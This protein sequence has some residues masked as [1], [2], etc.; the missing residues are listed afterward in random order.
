[1]AANTTREACSYG[2][3]KQTKRASQARG[4]VGQREGL[5]RPGH[6]SRGPRHPRALHEADESARTSP[7][8][9]APKNHNSCSD[10]LDA[11]A[12][13]VWQEMDSLDCRGGREAHL[14]AQADKRRTGA[15]HNV[16]HA[17]A[18]YGGRGRGV[19][20]R[21]HVGRA[22]NTRCGI[23]ARDA[24]QHGKRTKIQPLVVATMMQSSLWMLGARR[25]GCILAATR[26]RRHARK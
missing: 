26:T 13:H 11:A 25:S 2:G 15:S 22:R 5:A 20:N 4:K 10:G 18:T 3:H 8:H 21:Q 9:N 14:A 19:L 24:L 1:M 16:T 23:N 17:E 12:I 7:P 6:H